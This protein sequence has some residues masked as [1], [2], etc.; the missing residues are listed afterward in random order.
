ML[1]WEI[2]D[3]KFVKLYCLF[4]QIK[5]IGTGDSDYGTVDLTL[6]SYR[7]YKEMFQLRSS[8]HFHTDRTLGE[9]REQTSCLTTVGV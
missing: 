1:Y 3:E 9:G 6:T 5:V 2:T 4:S 8:L 7:L